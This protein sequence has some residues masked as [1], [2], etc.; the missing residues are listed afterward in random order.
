[1][2]SELHNARAIFLRVAQEGTGCDGDPFSA[3]TV[4][5]AWSLPD[6]GLLAED[7][8]EAVEDGLEPIAE[9]LEE[10][11]EP[12]VVCTSIHVAGFHTDNLG[13]IPIVR[14]SPDLPLAEIEG[15]H[16][17]TEERHSQD[18]NLAE[19]A[20]HGD[21]LGEQE[22]ALSS[23]FLVYEPLVFV[24]EILHLLLLIGLLC[25]LLLESWRLLLS[26]SVIILLR[27]L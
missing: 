11:E 1:M 17:V 22:V 3:R 5:E 21:G 26:E 12:I 16:V 13:A 20:V 7:G 23:S 14:L 18:T 8:G 4:L 10:A 25:S 24:I 27:I 19:S 15:D 2:H 6:G 9:L